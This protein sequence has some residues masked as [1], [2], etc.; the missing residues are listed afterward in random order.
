M[1]VMSC[2]LVGMNSVDELVINESIVIESFGEALTK[3]IKRLSAS[4]LEAVH[5]YR[6]LVFK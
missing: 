1:M 6:E 4:E 5:A 2:R 3:A